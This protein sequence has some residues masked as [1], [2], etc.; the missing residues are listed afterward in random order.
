MNIILTGSSSG[1]GLLTAKTLALAGHHVFATMRN[2]N[3]TN[4]QATDDVYA[5]AK[6]NNTK[7]TVVELDVTSDDS[8]TA[9]INHIADI[10]DGR[11]DGLINNAGSAFIGW[12]ETLSAAQTNQLFQINVIGV[13]RMIKAVIP[14]MRNNK[15]GTIITISSVAARRTTPVMGAYGASK[16][17]I[18]ALSSSYYYELKP[19]GIDV[20]ILQPGAYPATD[21]VAKQPIPANAAAEAYYPENMQ[22]YKQYVFELFSPKADSPNPQEVADAIAELLQLPAGNKPLWT[23]IGADA[24]RDFIDNINTE[25]KKLLDYIATSAGIL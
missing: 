17:A 5:W 24:G 7:I 25:T 20:A 21:I 10:T 6:A 2:I 1:F 19:F 14:F 3:G 13:D 15:S 12:N 22:L 8:V 9:A 16:A 18:D 4:K 11:I 23:L